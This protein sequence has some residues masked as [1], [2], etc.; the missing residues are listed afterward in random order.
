MANPYLSNNPQQSVMCVSVTPGAVPLSYLGGV[1]GSQA[2]H[3]GRGSS[4][5]AGIGPG[6]QR[7]GPGSHAGSVVSGASGQGPVGN[8]EKGFLDARQDNAGDRLDKENLE[9]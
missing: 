7:G 2:S 1:Q 8:Q 6:S 4:R 3:V 5:G 9:D